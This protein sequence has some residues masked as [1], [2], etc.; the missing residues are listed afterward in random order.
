MLIFNKRY[1]ALVSKYIVPLTD[2]G[3]AFS[4]L[5][6]NALKSILTEKVIKIESISSNSAIFYFDKGDLLKAL[7][8]DISLFYIRTILHREAAQNQYSD[9]PD[10]SINWSIVTD[11]YYAFFLSA[12]FLRLC[13]Q[14][15][16]Y[17][18]NSERDKI[19]DI[20]FNL[21]GITSSI[22]NNCYFKIETNDIDREYKLILAHASSKTHELVWERV[23]NVFSN[24]IALDNEQD[25]DEYTILRSIND[26]NQKMGAT[27]PSKLRNKVNYRPHYSL[28][29]LNREYYSPKVACEEN[30]WLSSILTYNGEKTEN[31]Q[32]TIN[33]FSAYI[34]YIQAFSFN[35]LKEYDDRR[36]RESGVLSSINK[37][38]TKKIR[39]PQPVFTYK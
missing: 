14:G 10:S 35:L 20:I 8:N 5:R 26:L 33:Y 1:N 34:R 12:L 25:S 39:Q 17:F 11:Y 6:Q 22:G 38:R 28:K 27:F 23:A 37:N 3:V 24:I 2:Y 15:T 9:S 29:E 19:R 16:F 7:V 18:D 13:H 21:S 36:G 32:L 30:H 4:K 31:D